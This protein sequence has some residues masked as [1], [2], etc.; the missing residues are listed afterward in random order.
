MLRLCSYACAYVAL[1]V[2]GLTAF[3]C[4]AF[5]LSLC[6]CLY[7]ASVNQAYV[8]KN[9]VKI[10]KISVVGADGAYGKR[11]NAFKLTT[12]L[13]CD[14][15]Q[16]EIIQSLPCKMVCTRKSKVKGLLLCCALSLSLSFSICHDI[17]PVCM[18]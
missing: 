16:G 6:L 5:C 17:I 15:N 7:A 8:L 11:F 1:Y 14:F 2:A 4:F 18:Q 13:T 3:L 12:L 9:K 10:K